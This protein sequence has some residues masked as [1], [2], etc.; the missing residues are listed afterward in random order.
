MNYKLY[1]TYNRKIKQRKENYTIIIIIY[2][3]NKLFE[4]ILIGI[5]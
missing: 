1:K 5:F 3:L 4:E 2:M